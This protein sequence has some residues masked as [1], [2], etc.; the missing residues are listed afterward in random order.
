MKIIR[1]AKCGKRPEEIGEY[2]NAGK[3]EGIS[4]SKF[5]VREEGTYNPKNGLFYCTSCYVGEGMPI[6]LPED[7]DNILEELTKFVKEVKI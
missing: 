7:I 6:G 3:V 2:I 4:P 5:I 1:C